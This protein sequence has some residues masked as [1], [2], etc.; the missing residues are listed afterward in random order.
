VKKVSE[1]IRTI[2]VTVGSATRRCRSTRWS[3][4]MGHSVRKGNRDRGEGAAGNAEKSRK[5]SRGNEPVEERSHTVANAIKA[6]TEI[7]ADHL[8]ASRHGHVA[9][10]YCLSCSS[11][12]TRARIQS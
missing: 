10:A 1:I 7:T 5:N 2:F 12:F 8:A 11:T 9:S 4:G 6:I 3:G